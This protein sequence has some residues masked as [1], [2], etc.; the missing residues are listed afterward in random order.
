[1]YDSWFDSILDIIKDK[2]RRAT[3]VHLIFV[4]HILDTVYTI[5]TE[6]YEHSLFIYTRSRIISPVSLRIKGLVVLV[7]V[8][9]RI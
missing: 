2:D 6:W 9:L 1:M 7:P 8:T 5:I 3:K 4:S